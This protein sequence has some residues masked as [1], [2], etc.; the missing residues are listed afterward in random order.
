MINQLP[1]EILTKILFDALPTNWFRSRPFS[2]ELSISQ[3][4]RYWRAICLGAPHLWRRVQYSQYR[5]EDEWRDEDVVALREYLQRSAGATLSVT[6]GGYRVSYDV[7]ALK[8]DKPCI[9][10]LW[11]TVFAES[12]RWRVVRLVLDEGVPIPVP[13]DE[14]LD[15]PELEEAGVMC[16]LD[17]DCACP[18]EFYDSPF[19]WFANA[20]KLRR[21]CIGEPFFASVVE[22]AWE[23]LT[24]LKLGLR[25]EYLQDYVTEILP[26]CTALVHLEVSNVY[27]TEWEEDLPVVGIPTL[28]ALVLH[29]EA[30]FLCFYLH[31]PHLERLALNVSYDGPQRNHRDAFLRLAQR[32][33]LLEL[34]DL[35]LISPLRNWANVDAMLEH[36]PGLTYLHMVDCSRWR[37]PPELPRICA[38]GGLRTLRTL[39][40]QLHESGWNSPGA[41]TQLSAELARLP[42]LKKFQMWNKRDDPDGDTAF[43]EQWLRALR[44]RVVAVEQRSWYPHLPGNS[45]AWE[46]DDV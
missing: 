26:T 15:I 21:L 23:R 40:L 1:P 20:P 14:P 18:I 45:G 5:N 25:A 44:E 28:R 2:K 46:S 41:A 43:D 27:D 8:G 9:R 39:S 33:P 35:Y 12:Q 17:P 6:M 10:D 4:C 19:R 24:H 3:V 31:V 22:V 34:R 36:T 7:D 29:D 37:P 32:H 13:Y 42:E 16:T 30:V 38:I 11:A